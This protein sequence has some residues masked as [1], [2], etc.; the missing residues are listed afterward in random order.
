MAFIRLQP[1]EIMKKKNCSELVFSTVWLLISVA[2]SNFLYSFYLFVDRVK[3]YH[4]KKGRRDATIV[5]RNIV[6][7]RK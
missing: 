1:G 5:Q 2:F 6:H 7:N 4:F 3:N